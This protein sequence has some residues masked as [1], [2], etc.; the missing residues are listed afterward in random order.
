MIAN[1][2]PIFA[3]CN[4]YIDAIVVSNLY[5]FLYKIIETETLK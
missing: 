2:S 4:G 5:T 1:L 3:F